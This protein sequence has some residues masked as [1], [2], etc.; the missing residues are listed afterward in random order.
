LQ[1]S[2]ARLILQSSF[3]HRL[4]HNCSLLHFCKC[5]S[6]FFILFLQNNNTWCMLVR[7][8]SSKIHHCDDWNIINNS[9]TP[10]EYHNE[11][12]SMVNVQSNCPN[13]RSKLIF[14]TWKHHILS[15]QVL[16]WYACVW[17]RYWWNRMAMIKFEREKVTWSTWEAYL[18]AVASC[19][20]NLRASSVTFC[21]CST[22]IKTYQK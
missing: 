15:R 19:S 16:N 12:N 2:L 21:S 18:C 11:K 4:S 1:F 14:I 22:R 5:N 13:Y 20:A 9:D 10:N 3:Q 17:G 8:Y 7:C 6:C